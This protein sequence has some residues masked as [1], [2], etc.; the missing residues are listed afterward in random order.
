MKTTKLLGVVFAVLLAGVAL[1]DTIAL[2]PNH[3]DRHVVVKGDT[4]W[5]IAGRFL[6]DPW[7]WPEVWYVN[8]QIKNPHLIYPGDVITL[9]Y[10]NG[11]P[12]LSVQRGRP[13]VVLKPHAR[14]EPL[15]NAIPTIPLDAIQQFLTE[16]LV[17]D[18]N[19][20]KHAPY[21]VEMADEHIIGGP[22]DSIY[23]RG[24]KGTQHKRF[25]VYRPSKPLIDPQTH[26]ILGYQAIYVGDATA[27]S[28]GDPSTLKLTH[29]SREA[30]VGDRLRAV[31]ES[32]INAN[33]V[34]HPPKK[35][36]DGRII[37]VLDGVTQVGQYQ[38]VVLNRGTR[39]GLNPGTVLAIY[40]AGRAIKDTVDG[41][42]D[43]VKLPDERAGVL[44]V[45][46]SF[47]RVSYGLVM[48]ATRALHVEDSV[49]NP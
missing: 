9:S 14:P 1:A 8:P 16:P 48:S 28:F 20:L 39:D 15:A 22:G 42:D 4:L 45:F 35:T 24:I 10:V 38:V 31:S 2:K 23:V 36:I 26:E 25:S 13:T 47:D 6:R 27:V 5:G 7:L 43:T 21:I 3:P 29:T 44:M 17:T 46:R 30:A 33:F 37:S 12:Q 41:K 11:K 49:R 18:K 32:Q 40:Q 19:E 34:P